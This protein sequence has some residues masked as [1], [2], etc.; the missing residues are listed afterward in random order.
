MF[1]PA[2]LFFACLADLSILT[3]AATVTYDWNVTWVWKSPDGF[4]RPVIGINNAWPCPQVDATAGD[5]VVINLNNKLGNQ[6]T[7]LHYH[8]INQVPTAN[9]DGPSGVTQCAVP[10]DSSVKYQFTADSPGT[11]WCEYN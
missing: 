8:G 3:K 6:T 7:G 10:P 4:G 2:T 11:Y 5:T 1:S 9:M